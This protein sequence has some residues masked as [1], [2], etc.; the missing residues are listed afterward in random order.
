MKKLIFILLLIFV[1]PP[2]IFAG[3][4]V[5]SLTFVFTGESNAGGQ[6]PNSGAT[7]DELASIREVQILN[8]NTFTFENLDIGTNNNID[9]WNM[10]CCDTHGF[11]LQLAN[12][13]KANAFTNN[14]QVHLV[15]TGQ[16]LSILGDWNVGGVFWNKFL[17]RVAAAKT[18]LPA[19]TQWVVWYS[20]GIN[21]YIFGTPTNTFKTMTIAHLN[22]IKAELPGAIIIMT[23]FQSMGD[24][25]T[26][27]MAEIASTQPNVY[28][29]DSTGAALDDYFHWSYT[30]YKTVGAKM[31]AITNHA[32]D[33]SVPTL[34]PT[35][36]PVS[37]PKKIQGDA[38]CDGQVDSTD[39]FYYVAAVNG[40]QIPANVSPD[41]NG[42]GE[43]GTADRTIITKSL[44]PSSN[45]F[46]IMTWGNNDS[47]KMQIAA[48]LGAK[49]YRPLA[50]I[51]D[52]N[53]L[54]CTEC[55]AAIDKGFKLVLTIRANGGGG[56]PTTPPTDWNAYRNRLS[57]VLDNY[58]P[59]ILVIENEE[60]SSTF[61]TGTSDQFLAELKVG[62]EVAHSKNIKCTNGG[63]VSKLVVVLV[64]E[65]YKPDTNKTDDYLKRALTPEDYVTVTES[66]GSPLWQDQI[67]K[68]RELL[69]GY[70]ASGADFVNFHWHQENAETLPEAVTY[71]GTASQGLPV[72][73]NEISPQKSISTNQVTS[74]M[75]KVFD[76]NWPYAI[77]YSNDADGVGGSTALTDKNGVLN[78]S[79]RAYQ[80]FI[81][82]RFL[83]TPTPLVLNRNAKKNIFAFN[84]LIPDFGKSESFTADMDDNE[85][86]DI[87]DYNLLVSNFGKS[88]TPGFVPADINKDGKVDIFD[89]NILV[90]NFGKTL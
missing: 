52:K 54:S 5:T 49:Y 58:Q 12:S 55:Q 48:D 33:M 43:V 82:D 90:A 88:G 80:Q 38:N 13:V 20:L 42:D 47:T 35:A 29:I 23:Q 17:Q 44:N 89:Y 11:E 36:T 60:N 86:V 28:V 62:C 16:G 73:N 22:K 30:G 81:K 39:Y 79:G 84:N 71:L 19:S 25:Y 1:F 56:N 78:D 40:G 51:L 6:A 53:P 15:K 67:K 83:P 4:P 9:H 31:I 59:E 8:N 10:I 26:S 24:I 68:G 61:Y 85:R 7:L 14:P 34:I 74:F 57:Q 75:Q 63:L 45:P 65:S 72:I 46:G 32:L 66:I 41:F 27:T 70:K 3:S 64:S 21:D 69:A 2:F 77:W 37:C 87:V 76:L 50:I 18:Q